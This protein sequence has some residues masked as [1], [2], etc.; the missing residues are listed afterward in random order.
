MGTSLSWQTGSVV[1]QKGYDCR[2][3]SPYASK[4][5]TSNTA[6]TATVV[7]RTPKA[8][9]AT[10]ATGFCRRPTGGR[11]LSRRVRCRLRV[12]GHVGVGIHPRRVALYAVGREEDTGNRIV[13]TG[14][15]VVQPAQAVGLLA[16]VA[17]AGA[18]VALLVLAL[19]IRLVALVAQHPRA[20]SGSAEAGH[21]AA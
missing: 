14:V 2:N 13:V 1:M 17:F 7:T 9:A 11:M 3:Y 10:S 8:S 20:A 5:T 15:I 16:G 21:H 6:R 12:A 4:D 19:A 18:Q